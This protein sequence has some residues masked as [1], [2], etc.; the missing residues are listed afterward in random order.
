M[1]KVEKFYKLQKLKVIGPAVRQKWISNFWIGRQIF[2]PKTDTI[3]IIFP[4][5][6]E[7]DWACKENMQKE[8]NLSSSVL[9]KLFF[10]AG[11]T[12][13]RELISVFKKKLV[14]LFHY[15]K[16]PVRADH[17]GLWFII[18]KLPL[19]NGTMHYDNRCSK[20]FILLVVSGMY[21]SIHCTYSN[22]PN[23][24]SSNTIMVEDLLAVF[25]DC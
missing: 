25:I 6:R 11:S 17:S 22:G 16:F 5:R 12:F 9:C 7:I 8:S 2:R 21:A 14:L 4:P 3:G 23:V 10:Q 13:N 24:A 20:D 1:I 18:R 19:I 15:A